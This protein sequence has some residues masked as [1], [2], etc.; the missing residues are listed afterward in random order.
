MKKERR[1][2]GN[3]FLSEKRRLPSQRGGKKRSFCHWEETDG[4]YGS[5]TCAFISL[6]H[7]C[8]VRPRW[9]AAHQP[10]CIGAHRR[11]RS[12]RVAALVR[13]LSAATELWWL[14]PPSRCIRPRHQRRV[15][16]LARRS[17]VATELCSL[18]PPSRS[19]EAATS[20]AQGESLRLIN[21]QVY[22]VVAGG[23]HGG[24]CSSL[25]A[26]AVG[27]GHVQGGLSTSSMS[28]RTNTTWSSTVTR[29]E[30]ICPGG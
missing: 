26:A 19:L 23:A 14:R 1:K 27:T 2:R 28:S 11:A 15:A 29:P 12:L 8:S 7:A 16:A 9:S 13:R 30:T 18:R 10:P 25:G 24:V 5:W 3:R 17:P 6:P 20:I 22:T 4:F 21:M